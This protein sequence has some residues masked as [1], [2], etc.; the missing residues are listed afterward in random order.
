M[1]VWL[2]H[3]GAD[4]GIVD[5]IIPRESFE[6]LVS[7]AQAQHQL[8]ALHERTIATA[9]AE[10][11]VLLDQARAEAAA[12][13]QAAQ[14]KAQEACR[15]GYRRGQRQA[16]DE[17]HAKASQAR[18]ADQRMLAAMHERLADMVAEATRHL[19][20]AEPS[21]AFF[22]A[23]ASR[24]DK[25]A[26]GATRLTLTVC[27]ADRAA[28]EAALQ[29]LQAPWLDGTTVAVEEDPALPPGSCRCESTTG[30][31]DASLDVQ[32]AAVRRAALHTLQRPLHDAMSAVSRA[33]QDE[34][35]S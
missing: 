10:A 2:R 12:I 4:V 25:L 34:A 5:G 9:Q 1:V 29:R 7:L 13:V 3:A 35:R 8:S 11:A 18:G 23:V 33:L 22:A 14:N 19:V 21:E 31:L 15:L 17:W 6:Q 30:W 26:E 27:P 32:L 16:L 28:A 24:M 20:Q